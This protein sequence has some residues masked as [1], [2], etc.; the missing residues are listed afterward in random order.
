VE[1]M[2]AVP[3]SVLRRERRAMA[4]EFIDVILKGIDYAE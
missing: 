1:N 3:P 2:F 4:Y